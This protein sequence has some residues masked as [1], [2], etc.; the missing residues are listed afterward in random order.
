M[1]QINELVN[2]LPVLI[3][4]I[5]IILTLICEILFGKNK[6]VVYSLSILSVL[7]SIAGTFYLL[8]KDLFVFG[9]LLRVNNITLAFTIIILTSVLLTFIASKNYLEKEKINFGEYYIIVLSSVLGML[10]MIFANDL[11]IVFI[12][13]ELMSICF[14]VL[15]GMLRKRVKSNESALKYFLLGAFISGFLLYGISLMYGAIGTTKISVYS[16]MAGITKTPVFLIGLVLYTIGFLFKMGVFPF[17][18]WVPD[19]YEGAPTIVTGMMSTAGKIAAVGTIAPLIISFNVPDFKT[20]LA[21]ISVLTM[22]FGNVIALSQSSIKRILAYS[23]I[24]SAGY[25]LVGVASMDEFAV[26]GIL[27]YL[28]AYVFMQ[29]GAFIVVSV[30]ESGSKDKTDFNLLNFDDYKGLAKRNPMLGIFFSVFLLS[31]AG[32][33]PLAGFWGKYY[34]FYVAIKSNLIWLSIIAILLS[35]VSLY[36]YLRIIVYMWFMEP[37]EELKETEIRSD[38]LSKIS[39]ILAFAGT[40]IFGFLPNIF[41]SLFNFVI[42]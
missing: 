24:A 19:V 23:S 33:P 14:Y 38:F 42:K 37:S 25:I 27:F 32:I 15:V 1:I 17:Q 7:G 21:I 18:M 2:I 40:V 8:N 9:E 3:I 35:L 39:L 4:F 12:G 11:L 10:L 16:T 34:L 36:Y 22:L 41:F 28:A 29:L 13:L 30:Y 6:L 20:L 5:G 31:L 26:K